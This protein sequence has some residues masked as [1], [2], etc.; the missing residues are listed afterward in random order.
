MTNDHLKNM[1]MINLLQ[2]TINPLHVVSIKWPEEETPVEPMPSGAT[3]VSSPNKIPA[4]KVATLTL[5]VTQNGL[6]L[7]LIFEENSEDYKTLK[8]AFGRQ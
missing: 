8:Q 7:T 3:E 5:S 6:P 1:T 4:S 2:Y